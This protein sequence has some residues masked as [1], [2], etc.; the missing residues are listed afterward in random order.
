MID[1]PTDISM[2]GHLILFAM[3]IEEGMHVIIF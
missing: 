2:T 3:I 1:D